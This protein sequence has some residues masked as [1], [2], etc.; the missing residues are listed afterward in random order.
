MERSKEFK[1]ASAAFRQHIPDLTIP[2]FTTAKEHDVYQYANH[3]KTNH[4][5]PWLFELTQ[6]WEKLYNEPYKGL[7]TDGTVQEGLFTV[8]DEDLP[9]SNIVSAANSLLSE[10]NDSQKSKLKYPINAR[11]WRAWSNPEILLRP[12]GLRLEEVPESIAQSILAV[13]EATLSKQ[14]YEKALAAMRINHFLG[15][16]VGLPQIMNKYSYN[17]LLF[18]EPSETEAWGWLLYGHHLD[19]S[20]F[21]KGKQ[22]FISPTFT[23]AEPNIIDD[24]PWT[25]TEILHTE[26][27]LGLKFMQSLTEEQQRKAQIYKLLHDPAMLQTGDLTKDR[28]NKDDQRHVCGAFRDNRIV[29]YE[30]INTA[31]LSEEQQNLLLSLAEQFVLYLPDTSRKLRLEQIKKHLKD[32][33]WCWIGGYGNDDAFYYRIQSPVFVAEFDHHSGVFLSNTEP[34]KFHTHTIVR[35]PNAGDYGSAI[36]KPEEKL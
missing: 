25:G 27:N 1:A 12:F 17:F 8:Q 28:W 19:L 20:V 6:A 18:G 29:P 10:L 15:E 5:P 34:A 35:T 11:E 26:G 24:G 32:T 2:R 22:I 30:G 3:F 4:A 9:I 36:R 16:V 7:T 13:M 21:I 33:Y 14:G 23:G 31:S